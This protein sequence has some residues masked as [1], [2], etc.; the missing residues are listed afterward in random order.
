MDHGATM[1]AASGN[2]A[3]RPAGSRG[4]LLQFTQARQV[5]ASVVFLA[6]RQASVKIAFGKTTDTSTT[7]RFLLADTPAGL[8]RQAQPQYLPSI[9]ALL[10]RFTPA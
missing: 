3:Y 10:S 2:C 9:D 7:F 5:A 4:A 1:A 6:F 8:A